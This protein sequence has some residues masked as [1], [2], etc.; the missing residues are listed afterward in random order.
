MSS[1]TEVLFE[2]VQGEGGNLGVITLNRPAALNSL[3]N[4]MVLAMH[5]QLNVWEAASHIKAVVIRAV[6]GKAFCAGGDIR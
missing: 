2:E 6:P 1:Y 4:H 3:N 5:E